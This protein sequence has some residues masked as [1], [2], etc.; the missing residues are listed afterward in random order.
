MR[1]CPVCEGDGRCICVLCDPDEDRF[2][3]KVEACGTHKYVY[4]DHEEY[5]QGCGGSGVVGARFPPRTRRSP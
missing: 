4:V 2:A 5:G 1:E 3:G